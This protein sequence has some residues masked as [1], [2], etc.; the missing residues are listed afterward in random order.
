MCFHENCDYLFKVFR[1]LYLAD[2]IVFI[3]VKGRHQ[4]FS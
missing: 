3:V 4:T 2:V 1:G